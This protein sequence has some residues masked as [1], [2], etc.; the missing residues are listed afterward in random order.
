[1]EKVYKIILVGDGNV[2]KTSFLR[3]FWGGDFKE[4]YVPTLGVEVHPIE[5]STN[6]GDFT[7]QVWDCAGKEENGGLRDGYY[8]QAHA[9]IFM[10]SV[11]SRE[12]YKNLKT[13]QRDVH[14]TCEEI[15]MVVC[16]NKADEKKHKVKGRH[17]TFPQ[18]YGFPFYYVSAKSNHNYEKPFLYLARVLTGKEDLIFTEEKSEMM[19]CWIPPLEDEEKASEQDEEKITRKVITLS[20]YIS[21]LSE[22]LKEHGDI[23]VGIVT[24][25]G[26]IQATCKMG[27][28]FV[29]K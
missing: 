13:W 15:P 8:I 2:G 29:G 25:N 20:T 19:E 7:F 4:E 28:S 16:G 5:F 12:S 27:A 26:Y 3:S 9:A 6:Y 14:R 1:M 11:T 22:T 18:E 17:I 23:P 10:F 24:M 21:Q